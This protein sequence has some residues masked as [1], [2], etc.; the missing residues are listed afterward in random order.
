MTEDVIGKLRQYSNAIVT[1]AYFGDEGA[2]SDAVKKVV[3]RLTAVYLG[4]DFERYRMNYSGVAG[5][6]GSD[7]D[8][9]MQALRNVHEGESEL[10]SLA[11]S[12][13]PDFG[14]IRDAAMDFSSRLDMVE[15]AA[16]TMDLQMVESLSKKEK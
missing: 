15:A 11:L 16:E 4:D 7:G 8:G 1:V 12:L 5:L 6:L 13:S 14:K 9:H 2:K 3:R 10:V